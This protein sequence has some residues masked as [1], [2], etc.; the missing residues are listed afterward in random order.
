MGTILEGEYEEVMNVVRDCFNELRRDCKR[1][2]V[3]IK[4]DYRE[5]TES[6]LNSKID[7]LQQK[8]GRKLKT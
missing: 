7:S 6:R 5:G 4:I 2:G 1:I 3:H 8:L